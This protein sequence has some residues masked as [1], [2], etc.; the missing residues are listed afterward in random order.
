[1]GKAISVPFQAL[2]QTKRVKTPL[3]L[4]DN[5]A[6]F[7]TD[8]PKIIGSKSSHLFLGCPQ[9]FGRNPLDFSLMS[10]PQLNDANSSPGARGCTRLLAAH[11]SP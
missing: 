8:E 5:A 7:Y 10:T 2:L 1:M 3:N 9:Q 11:N 4:W 6:K